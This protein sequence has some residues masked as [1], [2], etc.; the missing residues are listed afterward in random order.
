MLVEQLALA[1]K[2]HNTI[3]NSLD[4]KEMITEVLTTF[5]SETYAMYGEFLLLKD[6]KNYEKIYGFGKNR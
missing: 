4:L 3:G 6:D 1:Y 5:V 2:C